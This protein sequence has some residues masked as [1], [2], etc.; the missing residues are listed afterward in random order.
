MIRLYDGR[1]E[2]FQWDIDRK[3]IVD[4]EGADEVHFCNG[5][6][7]S[8]LV[9]RVYDEEGLKVAN[10]P[11]I[12][13]QNNFNIKAYVYCEGCYTRE[14]AVFKVTSRTRPEDY[15]YTETEVLRYIKL[16]NDIRDIQDQLSVIAETL[17]G[18]EIPEVEIPTE[19]PNP[20]ALTI[21]GTV[22]DG[23]EGVEIT[24]PTEDDIHTLIDKRLANFINVSEVAM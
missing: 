15:V 21:N 17:D 7:D 9:A 5:S 8:S 4:T 13:L 10:I 12:L 14:M 3:I 11:N 1:T 24:V 6:S 23:S 20:N 19:L 16:D 22:Y 2:L 18:L